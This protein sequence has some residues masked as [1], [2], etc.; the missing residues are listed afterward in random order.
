MN[1]GFLVATDIA[2]DCE[3]AFGEVE[4]ISQSATHFIATCTR[5]GR[6]WIL[7]GL[8]PEAADDALARQQLFKEYKILSMLS[9][10]GIVAFAGM[11][12]VGQLGLCI[13]MEWIDGPTLED[14]LRDGPLSRDDRRRLM[15]EIAEAVAYMH[16][17]GV[18]H[19]DLKLSNIM[20][21][22]NGGRA[23]IIDLGLAD[24]DAFTIVKYPAGTLGY[25]SERQQYATTPDTSD[26]IYSLGVVMRQLCPEYGAIARRCLATGRRRYRDGTLLV[27]VL[28]RRA[29]LRSRMVIALACAL[30]ATAIVGFTLYN[31]S[32]R[33]S[34]MDLDGQ[35]TLLR[36]TGEQ[37]RLAER[38]QR[39]CLTDSLTTLQNRLAAESSIRAEAERHEQRLSDLKR[40][41]KRRCENLYTRY[42]T[43]RKK[44][45]FREVYDGQRLIE[46]LN[47]LKAEFIAAHRDLTETD[48]IEIES[49]FA[50]YYGDIVNK[51]YSPNR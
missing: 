23:V 21:R 20:V 33:S 44:S 13:V 19:R 24:T 51:Y 39:R 30:V 18:V 32:L 16:S 38:R 29:Q 35:L 4:I 37:E 45:A 12:E 3:M 7:K 11:D 15:T 28:R 43:D 50:T 36:Q 5:Y 26:D 27:R 14:V 48:R 1:S 47:A 49:A 41:L 25:A 34:V 31:R 8:R 17:R 40:Q 10:P 9:H 6:R 46:G 42:M 22:R 2:S